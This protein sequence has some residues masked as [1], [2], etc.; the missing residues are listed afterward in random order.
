MDPNANTVAP[1]LT[2][3][4][5]VSAVSGGLAG[6]IF[7]FFA[8][9]S[10]QKRATQASLRQNG[11]QDFKVWTSKAYELY[12]ANEAKWAGGVRPIDAK[13][14]L[15]NSEYLDLLNAAD[16]SIKT[17]FNDSEYA[18]FRDFAKRMEKSLVDAYSRGELLPFEDYHTRR[19]E[20]VRHLV[21]KL[22]N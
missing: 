12:M 19:E 1:T 18:E 21:E 5:I 7:T 6:A 22:W 13:G 4:V 17:V 9:K 3:S 8:Q 10:L 14:T 15:S 16:L 20:L 11:I 2:L